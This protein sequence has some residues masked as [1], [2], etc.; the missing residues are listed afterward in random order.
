MTI[1]PFQNWVAEQ[2]SLFGYSDRACDKHNYAV[3]MSELLYRTIENSSEVVSIKGGTALECK[4]AAPIVIPSTESEQTCNEFDS[5]EVIAISV[6]KKKDEF[7]YGYPDQLSSLSTDIESLRC[8]YEDLPLTVKQK[9]DVAK[10]IRILSEAVS[11][12]EEV[13]ETE[14]TDEVL[15]FHL[16]TYRMEEYYKDDVD[17]YLNTELLEYLLYQLMMKE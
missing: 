15:E 11:S 17:F 9:E 12:E 8:S 1:V 16:L 3:K 5:D 2:R 14:C 6:S 10:A 4:F 13:C 7:G